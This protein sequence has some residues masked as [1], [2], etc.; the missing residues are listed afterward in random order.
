MRRSAAMV[1]AI[2]AMI[3]CSSEEPAAVADSSNLLAAGIK[4]EIT[5]NGVRVTN[6]TDERVAFHIRNPQWLGLLS[7]CETQDTSCE[8]LAADSEMTVPLDEIHGF[9]ADGPIT[10]EWWNVERAG[11]GYR[12]GAVHTITIR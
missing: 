1:F 12:A 7:L 9:S 8:R 3:G 5:A 6:G 10:F 2:S 11:D 4:A